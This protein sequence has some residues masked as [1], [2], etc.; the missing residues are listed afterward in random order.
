[1]CNVPAMSSLVQLEVHL[2]ELP[3][4]EVSGLEGI[5]RNSSKREESELIAL[6]SA[7]KSFSES[8]YTR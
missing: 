2:S 1:M 3:K 4:K 6:I 8:E 7:F 5:G